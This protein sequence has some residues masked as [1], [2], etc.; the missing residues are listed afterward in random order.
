MVWT[1][2]LYWPVYISCSNNTYTRGDARA[3]PPPARPA[4]AIG[5]PQLPQRRCG[6]SVRRRWGWRG[7]EEDS[8]AGLMSRRGTR[9]SPT[10]RER[11]GTHVAVGVGVAVVPS[12]AVMRAAAA[13]RVRRGRARGQPAASVA[14]MVAALR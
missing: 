6:V 8:E 10:H 14:A 13:R 12:V 5:E 9:G 11:I 1:E 2:H 4:P 3:G 7:A